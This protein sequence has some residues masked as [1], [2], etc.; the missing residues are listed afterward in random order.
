L[1]HIALNGRVV[2]IVFD[3][4][5]STKSAV[6]QALDRFREHLQRKG[7]EVQIIYLPNAPTERRLAAMT[8]CSS[9]ALLTPRRLPRV[10]DRHLNRPRRQ[11]AC[12]SRLR[13]G[14]TDLCS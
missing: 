8:S 13:H 2:R 5:V 10:R 11:S 6:R 4:D 7:A 9:T 12:S 3:S 14:W 1:D